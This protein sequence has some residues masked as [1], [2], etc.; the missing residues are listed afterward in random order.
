MPTRL[1]L[2]I[3]VWVLALVPAAAQSTPPAFTPSDCPFAIPAGAQVDCGTLTVPQ[4][5]AAPQA[6]SIQLAIAIYRA[7]GS[8]AVAD[9][10]VFLQG[11]PGAGI[12]ELTPQL[13]QPFIA[14]LTQARDMVFID[15]RGTGYSTPALSCPEVTAASLTD[16]E[17]ILTA[18]EARQLYL[19]AFIACRDRLTADGVDIAAFTSAASAADIADLATALG[20]AQVNLYGSSY[21]TRLAQTV[22]RDYPDLV[23]SAVL[24]SAIPVEVNLYAGQAY[25]AEF[26]I[27]R[28]LAACAAQS[29]CADFYPTLRD[30]FYAAIDRL[31]AQPQAI[32]VTNPISGARYTVQVSGADFITGTFITMQ[33][34]QFLPQI[35]VL[36]NEVSKGNTA[37]LELPFMLVLLLSDQIDIGLFSS[38]NCHEEVFATTAQDIAQAWAQ[39]PA[40]ASFAAEAAYGSTDTLT[41]V[42]QTWGAQPFDPQEALPVTAQT[43]VLALAGEFDPATPVTWTQQT[44]ANFPNSFYFEFPA[45]THVVGQ[46]GGCAVQIVQDFLDAPQTAPNADCIAAMPPIRFDLR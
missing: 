4:N 36:M 20:Y 25:K 44:A 38:I 28:L 17:S 45:M 34:P 46:S 22:I 15:Q 11:G 31:N 42:C 35:P 24:D 2:L 8:A 6:A 19:P 21:G 40:F 43:P 23:R 5:R 10:I 12:I 14:P 18:E 29:A 33:V 26:A 37:A 41:E 32:T 9:P 7:S 30:D 1:V 39:T 13:Y 3:V 16:L 27:E